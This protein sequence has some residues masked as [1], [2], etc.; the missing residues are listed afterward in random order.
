MAGASSKACR[1]T[2]GSVRELVS[3]FEAVKDSAQGGRQGNVR[4]VRRTHRPG[5]WPATKT[6]VPVRHPFQVVQQKGCSCY[7]IPSKPSDLSPRRYG[8]W[9]TTKTPAPVRHPRPMVETKGSSCS[10]IPSKPSD[11]SP[12][13]GSW[14][15]TKTSAPVRHPCQ[16]VEKKGFSCSCIPTKPSDL[17]ARKSSDRECKQQRQQQ[18]Q[19]Q[20]AKLNEQQ[21]AFLAQLHASKLERARYEFKRQKMRSQSTQETMDSKANLP[22]AWQELLLELHMAQTWRTSLPEN[23]VSCKQPGPIALPKLSRPHASLLIASQ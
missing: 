17:S 7:C 11:F 5:S 21:L 20:P 1:G 23:E 18:L 13:L 8:S 15:A 19:Q 4:P 14:Q 6:P 10:C 12:R 16:V 22:L 3:F 2:A 9:P